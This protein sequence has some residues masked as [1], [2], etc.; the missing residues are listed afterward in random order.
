MAARI[1]RPP[2]MFTVLEDVDAPTMMRLVNAGATMG[3]RYLH[4]NEVRRRK[5]PEGLTLEQWWAGMRWARHLSSRRTGLLDTRGDPFTYSLVDPL[6]ERLHN[7]DLRANG[8][9]AAPAAVVDRTTR[10]NY[11][12][13]GLIEEAISSSQL[14]GAATTRRAAKE[15]LRTDR[16]PRDRSERMIFNNYRTIRRIGEVVE[17]DLTPA[18]L[19]ELHAMLTEETLN[20]PADAGRFQQPGEDRVAVYDRDGEMVHQPPPAEEIPERI[21]QLCGFANDQEGSFTHP[22]VKAIM[23]HF[24]LAYV[25]PFADGNGRTARAL[26]YWCALRAGYWLVEFVSISQII[27]D[28]PA[29]YER[30]FIHSETDGNDL[31]YFLIHQLDVL[32]RAFEELAKYVDRTI[33]RTRAAERAAGELPDLNHRQRTILGH[34]LRNP[35]AR[36]TYLSHARSHDVTRQT[37]RSDLIALK[38]RGWLDVGKDGRQVIL[39]AP[40][41]LAARLSAKRTQPQVLN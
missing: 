33:E 11:M 17:Q 22:L 37:A 16:R 35:G 5:P 36:Y 6:L 2:Q 20:K 12:V 14:E 30:A 41:D 10:D 39:I 32:R 25:H 4:W 15:M 27:L 13:R 9:T 18:L 40:E 23:L 31:T 21:N 1:A 29:Q 26:F 28:A 8:R 7:L 38:N 3:G 24:W 34:A 19:M